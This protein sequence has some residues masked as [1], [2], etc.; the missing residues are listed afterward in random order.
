MTGKLIVLLQQGI[1]LERDTS[2]VCTMLHLSSALLL[3]SFPLYLYFLSVNSKIPEAFS[4]EEAKIRNQSVSTSCSSGYRHLC[5]LVCQIRTLS[6]KIQ[7][8][9]CLLFSMTMG[10]TLYRVH[11]TYYWCCRLIS[12]TPTSS[13]CISKDSAHGCI[14]NN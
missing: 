7:F 13:I 9:N 8:K 6:L 4:A 5:V 11:R 3:S 10:R 1:P 12:L 14:I 2:Y